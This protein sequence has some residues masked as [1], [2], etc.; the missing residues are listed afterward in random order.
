MAKFTHTQA[1][2][3][4][5]S[6]PC[7]FSMPHFTATVFPK[8]KP[9]RLQ[10]AGVEYGKWTALFHENRRS[11]CARR[12]ALVADISLSL[13]LFVCLYPGVHMYNHTATNSE[14]CRSTT[15]PHGENVSFWRYSAFFGAG[16]NCFWHRRP[17]PTTKLRL[18]SKNIVVHVSKK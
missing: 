12:S 5:G 7:R 2:S 16:G 15:T 4:L 11:D 8:I 3:S 10:M 13:S 9:H 6:S 14:P 1:S 17:A 18:S